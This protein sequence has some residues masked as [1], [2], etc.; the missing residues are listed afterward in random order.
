MS[1][2]LT[3]RLLA[4][5]RDL[6]LIARRIADGVGFGA[7]R[8]RAPGPGLEFTQYRPYQPGDD[9]RRLDWKLAARSDRFFIR[10]S[11]RESSIPLRLMVDATGSMAY[12]D[13]EVSLLDVARILAA[14]LA[15]VADRQGDA[16][17]LVGVSD[18][19]PALVPARREHA[20]LE[21]VLHTLACMEPRGRWPSWSILEGA[22]A[23]GGRGIT[24]LLTDAAEEADEIL[25]AIRR[26]AALRHDVIVFH[27]AGRMVLE[28]PWE[29]AVRFEEYE[30]GR[31]LDVDAS[32]A[33]ERVRNATQRRF[34][35]FERA[36]RAQGAEYQLILLD[37]PVE[38]ALRRWLRVRTHW[39]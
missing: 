22:V 12:A 32:L 19:G 27:L 16:V 23:A 5:T 33:R 3:P 10:E 25:A 2:L 9:L 20:Q 6:G 14:G 34:A 18:A 30:T 8:S 11:E 36:V 38:L 24:V 17:G 31:K 13:A 29:G 1:V 4:A 15:L 21:R 26:L 37:E 35:E 7:H 39:A 28:F